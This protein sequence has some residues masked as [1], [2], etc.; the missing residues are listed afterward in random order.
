MQTSGRSHFAEGIE[1]APPVSGG[2]PCLE[3]SWVEVERIE[4]ELQTCFSSL[5]HKNRFLASNFS[6]QAYDIQ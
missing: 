6:S 2:G 4:Q 5:D 3:N 1:V